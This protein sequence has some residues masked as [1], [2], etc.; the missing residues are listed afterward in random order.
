MSPC[1]ICGTRTGQHGF[2]WENDRLSPIDHAGI[3]SIPE[4]LIPYEDGEPED[5][6]AFVAKLIEIM[7]RAVK[8]RSPV[9]EI[10]II[11]RNNETGS[12]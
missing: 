12:L 8:G 10:C 9:P 2:S 4:E 1:H 3:L 11:P 7:S 5:E 6:D